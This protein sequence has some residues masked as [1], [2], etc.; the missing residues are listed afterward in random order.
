MPQFNFSSATRNRILGSASTVFVLAVLQLLS[1]YLVPLYEQ[2]FLNASGL[3]AELLSM[4]SLVDIA[5]SFED[6][7]IVTYGGREFDNLAIIDVMIEN[8]G[9]KPIRKED[10][11]APL[12]FRFPN[13]S[14]VLEASVIEA[15]PGTLQIAVEIEK[16]RE[17]VL[18]P[19][20]LN[21]GDR[22][23]FRF[24][25][26][27]MPLDSESFPLALDGRIADI[28]EVELIS[29]ISRP[30]ADAPVG[31]LSGF[32]GVLAGMILVCG[33]LVVGI[34]RAISRPD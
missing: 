6:K 31:A 15:K 33:L 5:P 26:S 23:I 19:T 20:L 7:V 13:D 34:V 32:I 9:S 8:T 12:T 21:Q 27:N 28:P 10:F 2:R 25:I 3:K 4:A 17:V 16:E 14:E 18:V 11:E 1:T 29:S 24:V 22:A 30:P